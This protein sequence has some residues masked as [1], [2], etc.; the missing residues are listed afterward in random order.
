MRDL[1]GADRIQR[2]M[3]SLGA[4]ARDEA[5]VYLTGGASAVL[6]G[7]R[8]QTIDVDASIVPERDELLRAIPRLK[9]ELGINVE[10]ASPA[11]FI[12]TL[13]TSATFGSC[14]TGVSSSGNG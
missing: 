4:A 6:L 2:F 3:E 7:W 8:G 13:W 1:A 11:D 12:R 14:S 5:R 9:E 10:L